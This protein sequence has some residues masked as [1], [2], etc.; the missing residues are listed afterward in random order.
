MSG[1]ATSVDRLVITVTG[2]P[3]P[4]GSKRVGPHGQMLEQSRYLPAWRAA[5]KRCA[6]RAYRDRGIGPEEIAGGLFAGP[7]GVN[8]TFYLSPGQLTLGRIDGPPDLDKLMRSTWDALTEAR[9]WADDGQV[10]HIEEAR[11][12]SADGFTSGAV[13]TVWRVTEGR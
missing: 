7:V 13:I 6:Y 2:R 5:V 9:V 3:A 4:Q 1:P 10:V 8:V 11:K 12:V